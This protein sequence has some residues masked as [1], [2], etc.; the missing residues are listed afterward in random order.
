FQAAIDAARPL[1]TLLLEHITADIDGRSTE[2]RTQIKERARPLLAALPNDT[3]RTEFGK[4]LARL[5]GD[6]PEDLLAALTAT[7]TRST[8]PAVA[9][10]RSRTSSRA[11]RVTA[12]TRALQL[13]M[14]EPELAG[15][16]DDLAALRASSERGADVVADAVEFFRNDPTLPI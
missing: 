15:H 2:G 5:T 7:D 4:S 10:P 6:R 11:V 12:V 16:V 14:H 13:L 1:S 8:A 3:F 9:S